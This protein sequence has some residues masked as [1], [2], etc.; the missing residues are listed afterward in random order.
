MKKKLITEYFQEIKLIQENI[1]ID[2]IEKIANLLFKKITKK[3]KYLL[4]VMEGQR[5]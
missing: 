5:L 4:Q 2:V 1:E 3:K